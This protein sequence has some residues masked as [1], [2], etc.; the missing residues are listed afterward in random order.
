[1]ILVV[2]DDRNVRT[3]LSGLLRE[4]G[5]E[6]AEAGDVPEAL[7]AL[8]QGSVR[9]VV[10]DLRMP[11]RDGLHLLAEVRRRW[12]AVPVIL[13]TAYADVATAVEAMKGGARDF[14]TK[15]FDEEELLNAVRK[16]A[17]ESLKNRQMVSD[18]FGGDDPLAGGV[19]GG[20]DS[21]GRV[22]EAVAAVAPSEAT[23]LITGETGVGKELVARAVHRASRRTGAPFVKVNCAAIPDYLLE[24]ELF[25]H[26]KGAFTGAVTRK[27][28]RFE[29]AHGG[30]LFLDEVGELPLLLQPKLLGVLQDGAFE[31]VGGVDTIR[32]DLRVV[33][34]TNRDLEEEVAAGRFRADLYY[35]LNVV[36]IHVPPL[37][38]RPEDV[39]VLAEHFAAKHAAA[40]GRTPPRVKPEAAALL[41]AHPWPGNVRELENLME[42]LLVF[43]PSDE[44]V[45]GDL[46][47][48][49]R[50][51]GSPAG[52]APLKDA[53][54]SLSRSAER[55]MIREALEASGQN[56]THAARLL[57]ISRRAL[58]HKIKD[59]GL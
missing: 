32:V 19:A 14:I 10:T 16:A 30:T 33:A 11:G 29:L 36:P 54:R 35:R 58:Q 45:P 53:V 23:V 50:Q 3:V 27:P 17:G 15:P 7:D 26:E 55:Q 25:G 13:V 20:S 4:A 34:A 37:R 38:E 5:Y 46:P 41:M 8:S 1:M 49:F 31:R 12:P 59:Y 43:C 39:P 56:R 28:G 9:V 6:A 2:D 24:S 22:L 51:E 48:E 47:E 18:Y 52:A 57:G 42:R 44:I 21:M 40:H